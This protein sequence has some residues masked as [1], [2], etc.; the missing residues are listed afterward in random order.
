MWKK[1]ISQIYFVLKI[2]LS[3]N[4]WYNKVLMEIGPIGVFL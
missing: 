1:Q 3:L 4:H 2:K